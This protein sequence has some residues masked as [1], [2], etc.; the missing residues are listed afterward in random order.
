[1]QDSRHAPSTQTEFGGQSP[2]EHWVEPVLV[3][4]EPVEAAV[5]EPDDPPVPAGSMTASPP[6]A[7]KP[8]T[9]KKV[10]RMPRSMLEADR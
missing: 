8:K 3:E 2:K 5:V 9:N 4:P 6:H 1:M 7:T 10:Q